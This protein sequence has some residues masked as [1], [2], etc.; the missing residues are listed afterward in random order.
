MPNKKIPY[1]VFALNNDE[2]EDVIK[3][4]KKDNKDKLAAWL[5]A[6]KNVVYSSDPDQ[7]K[8]FRN[9]KR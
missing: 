4:L 7:W 6:N 3:K 5:E 9:E 2:V 8:P 1:A